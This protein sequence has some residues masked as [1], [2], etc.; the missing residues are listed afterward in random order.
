[1]LLN[2][3]SINFSWLPLVES[4]SHPI[5][6]KVPLGITLGIEQHRIAELR[7]GMRNRHLLAEFKNRKRYFLRNW[8]SG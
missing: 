5:R 6:Q 3:F 2:A 8:T 1:M 7:C 4:L